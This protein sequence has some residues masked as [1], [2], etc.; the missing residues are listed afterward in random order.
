MKLAEG[1]V[2]TIVTTA[3]HCLALSTSR[4]TLFGV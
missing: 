4:S 3:L 1:V 2:E